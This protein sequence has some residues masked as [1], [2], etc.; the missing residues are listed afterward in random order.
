[1]RDQLIIEELRKGNQT[2][3]GVLYEYYSPIESH[4][5]QNK[6]TKHDAKDIF[7]NALIIFYKKALLPDFELN[8]KISTYLFGVSK[9][10]W[11][12]QLRLKKNKSKITIENEHN[13]VE[14]QIEMG[15]CEF[16]LEVFIKD[17]LEQL[18]EP[19]LSLLIMHTY[20]KLSMDQITEKLGYA[21][22]H[23]AWQQKYKCLQRLKKSIPFDEIKQHLS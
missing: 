4:I 16:N 7:Q 13:T 23:T 5:I 3:F 10:L 21:N 11:L 14:Q 15:S 19:C 9:N 12:N 1:M 22:N 18:G 2:I 17:K 20:K 8:A 6:G